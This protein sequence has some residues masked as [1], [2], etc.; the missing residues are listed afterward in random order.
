MPTGLAA[1]P[2]AAILREIERRRARAA[3]LQSE[4]NRL[5]RRLQS[6]DARM[7]AYGGVAASG[8]AR[9]GGRARNAVSLKDAL[10]AALKGKRMSIAEGMEAVRRAGYRTNAA[11]F[12]IMVTI[13]LG[14]KK[15]FTRVE[16]G[17]YTAK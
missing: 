12:R 14:D 10:A 13:A 4:R 16:R 15:V 8:R 7:A 11:S 2:P 5:L 17:V 3:N 9:S 6:L 1:I